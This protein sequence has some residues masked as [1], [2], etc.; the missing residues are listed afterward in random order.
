M[1]NM[2]FIHGDVKYIIFPRYLF[3]QKLP[4]LL[5]PA[6]HCHEKWH[7]RSLQKTRWLHGKRKGGCFTVKAG[8]E[9]LSAP[10]RPQTVQRRIPPRVRAELHAL[11]RYKHIRHAFTKQRPLYNHG[12]ILNLSPQEHS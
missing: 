8:S 3:S 11:P 10:D 6:P 2:D 4:F 1:L 5:L 12:L 7:S 9:Q